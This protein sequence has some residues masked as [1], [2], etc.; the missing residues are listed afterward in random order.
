M[1][2]R[3]SQHLV[4]SYLVTYLLL[5]LLLVPLDPQR[6]FSSTM[7]NFSFSAL[8]MATGLG[9]KK[10]RRAMGCGAGEG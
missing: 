2:R 1:A 7:Q 10:V 8:L 3:T 4:F 6:F 5:L 9:A